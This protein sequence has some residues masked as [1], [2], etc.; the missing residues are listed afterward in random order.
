MTPTSS[1]IWHALTVLWEY[2][3]NILCSLTGTYRTWT[4]RCGP[5]L[6]C[7]VD[8]TFE[9]SRDESARPH[10][11]GSN[12]NAVVFAYANLPYLLDAIAEYNQGRAPERKA[13]E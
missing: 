2:D 9:W 6:L 4:V 1:S 12:A 3:C 5:W 11:F 10:M 7:E 8:K 13:P